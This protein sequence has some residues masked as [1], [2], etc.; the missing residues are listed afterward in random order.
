M[1]GHLN[2]L[3]IAL[4]TTT[5][6]ACG[7]GASGGDNASPPTPPTPPAPDVPKG[8]S[9]DS[10]T[11]DTAS[12]TG[13]KLA[14]FNTIN[15]AR[16]KAG[17]APVKQNTKLDKAAQGHAGYI[18]LNG[19]GE[20]HYQTESKPGFTG[21][22]HLA[23]AKAALYSPVST[24]VGEG[25]IYRSVQ[26]TDPAGAVE[27]L[28]NTV[29]HRVEL[30]SAASAD[31]GIGIDTYEQ[32]VPGYESW[33]GKATIINYGLISVARSL[34]NESGYWVWPYDGAVKLAVAYGENPN[35]A[36]DLERLGYPLS[37]TVNANDTITADTFTVNC[38][39][40]DLP[41]RIITTANDI[42]Q[43]IDASWVFL[44]PEVAL[45]YDATCVAAFAGSSEKL[46][47]IN[48]TW[49][50]KTTQQP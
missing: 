23:R 41:A 22:D 17:L 30:L 8:S 13:E 31:V 12:Y 34:E 2:L 3:A 45:P 5:L 46:G 25:I 29:Y 6:A 1:K 47:H 49:S 42:H 11:L 33:H 35:P 21:V 36:P 19:E 39:G 10:G 40:Q 20:S 50:F 4:V 44:Q 38:A 7:G 28:L 16:A 26:A 18:H 43:M 15:E 48:H 27:G 9:G 37:L 32:R 14:I 24:T